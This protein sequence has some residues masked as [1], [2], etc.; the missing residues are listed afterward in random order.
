MRA[1]GPREAPHQL[2][3]KACFSL[4]DSCFS[5][6]SPAYRGSQ[7]QAMSQPLPLGHSDLCSTV[8]AG[9][10]AVWAVQITPSKPPACWIQ[11][12]TS[13][14]VRQGPLLSPSAQSSPRENENPN[15]DV[16]EH[17]ELWITQ[18][19]S[20]GGGIWRI[21]EMVEPQSGQKGH[22]KHMHS[23]SAAFLFSALQRSHCSDAILGS[24][25]LCKSL[26]C[27]RKKNQLL[28]L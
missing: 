6:S 11:C 12:E 4:S 14:G 5:C 24:N 26:G 15:P 21:S 16:L 10:H 13:S 2:Q 20:W 18:G 17:F 7:S 3:E 9:R 25:S 28:F 27:M 8:P 22:L 1:L 23:L 19:R